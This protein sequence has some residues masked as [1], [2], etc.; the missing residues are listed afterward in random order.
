MYHLIPSA[1]FAVALV[2]YISGAQH[3]GLFLLL[4]GGAM[5]MTAWIRIIK[6]RQRWGAP[7]LLT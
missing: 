6:R 5:E 1:C 4:L 3:R 7:D 2:C